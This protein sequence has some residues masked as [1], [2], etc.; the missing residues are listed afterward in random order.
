[1]TIQVFGK[2]GDALAYV[3][4]LSNMDLHALVDG[5]LIRQDRVDTEVQMV[6]AFL[7][8]AAEDHDMP[9]L[10]ES[11]AQALELDGFDNLM[12]WEDA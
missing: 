10:A 5:N 1:M 11:L 2:D 9:H 6:P 3:I 12:D 8:V 7:V 4:S